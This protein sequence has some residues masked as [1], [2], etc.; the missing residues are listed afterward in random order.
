MIKI[1]VGEKQP[2]KCQK[3][4]DFLGYE[5]HDT[6]RVSIHTELKEGEPALGTWE[7]KSS[8]AYCAECG[9]LLPFKLKRETKENVKFIIK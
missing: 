8:E 3:C 4:N 5:Y 6:Y 7:R 9:S 1:K 2:V